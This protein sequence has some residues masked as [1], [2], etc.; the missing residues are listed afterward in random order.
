[1]ATVATQLLTA[2]EFYEWANRPE[3][4]GRIC[5]LERGRIIEIDLVADPE[6]LSQLELA[7]LAD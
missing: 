6:R 5:E 1:M 2:E 3:N 4:R 7:I